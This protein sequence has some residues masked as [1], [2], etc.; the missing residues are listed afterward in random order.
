VISVDTYR[1]A[2]ARAAVRA[3]ASCINDVRAGREEGMLA[4][5]AQADVPVVLMHS[6]GDST[7]MANEADYAHGVVA[8]LAA[9]LAQRVAAARAAGVKRWD[10][11]L[12]PGLGFAKTYEQNLVLVR[13][14][15][16]FA[17]LLPGY[18]ILVGASR[19]GF[20]GKAT[21]IEAAQDRAPG[22]AAVNALCAVSGVVD[23]L[24]VHDSA[25]ARASV[26]MAV[27]VRDAREER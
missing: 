16:T 26:R 17:A 14:M 22:D 15:P 8:G 13:D 19:K 27:A 6:R 12:D 2:V 11:V 21:G 23:V 1:A 18:P 20:V 7:S 9:E 3:G 25:G 5:M 4:A 10:I 24:R